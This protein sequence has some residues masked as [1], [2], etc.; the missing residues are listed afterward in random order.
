MPDAQNNDQAFILALTE[1]VLKNLKNEN[2]R[3]RNLA[4]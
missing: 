4:R 2:F 3:I 1:I